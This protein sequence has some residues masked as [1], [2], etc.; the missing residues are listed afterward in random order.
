MSTIKTETGK[1]GQTVSRS[2]LLRGH[3]C[4]TALFQGFGD[5]IVDTFEPDELQ[6]IPRTLRNFIEVPPVT[7]REHH[8]GKA[9]RGGGDDFFLDAANRQHQTPQRYLA[10][11]GG[12][13]SYPAGWE[14]RGQRRG[15]RDAGAPS[16]LPPGAR[17]AMYLDVALF[18]Y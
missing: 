12:V 3:R 6:L 7:R 18:K 17:R 13:R 2:E 15:H 9:G 11:H 5:R 16:L 1:S 14:Q 8:P 10:G 4:G